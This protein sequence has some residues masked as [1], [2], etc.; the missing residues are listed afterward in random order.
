MALVLSVHLRICLSRLYE[1]R[2]PPQQDHI[3]LS[4][5]IFA[6]LTIVHRYLEKSNVVSVLT[7]QRPEAPKTDGYTD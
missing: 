7:S 5:Q 1:M 4:L 3:L 2:C 6:S